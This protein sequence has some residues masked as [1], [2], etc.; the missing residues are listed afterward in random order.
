[1]KTHKTAREELREGL[2][3]LLAAARK[4]AKG[5]EPH[6]REPIEAAQKLLEN[7]GHESE[8]IATEV[9]REVA[10]FAA[11]LA[12]RLREVADRAEGG[13]TAE[14]PPD[15]RPRR[16][17]HPSPRCRSCDLT[18]GITHP[19]RQCRCSRRSSSG[20]IFGEDPEGPGRRHQP[21]EGR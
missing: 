20:S 21:R 16:D 19:R 11:R 6:V 15:E 14:R 4:T 2:N 5:I 18:R 8:V 12:E 7:I 10:T 17:R 9:T 13:R 3:H 1:M